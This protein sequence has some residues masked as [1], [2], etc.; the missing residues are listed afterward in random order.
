MLTNSF[1]KLVLSRTL[2]RSFA[3][4]GGLQKFDYLDPLNFEGLLTDEEKMVQENA[5]KYA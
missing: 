3:S 1:K 4:S 2:T 5:R